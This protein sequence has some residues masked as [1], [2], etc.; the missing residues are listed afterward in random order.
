[1]ARTFRR[2]QQPQPIAE[3]NITNLVDLGFTLL[4]IFMIAT[5]LI[6]QDQTTPINLPSSSKLQTQP[7]DKNTQVHAVSVDAKG[8]FFVDGKPVTLVELRSTLR[9]YATGA[10]PPVIRI[11]GDKNVRFEKVYQ[12]FD[13]CQKANLL[14]VTIDSQTEG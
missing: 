1:M 12:V 10:K 5:P 2:R 13:E 3:L 9:G 7:P 6:T 4:I 14:K 11:R 8:G